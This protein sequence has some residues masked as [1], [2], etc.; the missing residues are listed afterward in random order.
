MIVLGVLMLTSYFLPLPLPDSA[1]HPAHSGHGA[2][3]RD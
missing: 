2:R 3:R 1:Q